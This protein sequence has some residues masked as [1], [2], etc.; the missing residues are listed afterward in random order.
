MEEIEDQM[1][2]EL[3]GEEASSAGS[4]SAK[5]V[6]RMQVDA[7]YERP[8][9]MNGIGDE[10]NNDKKYCTLAALPRSSSSR[11]D[12]ILY[13]SSSGSLWNGLLGSGG[14]MHE[15]SKEIEIDQF[16]N[17]EKNRNNSYAL[18]E[19]SENDIRCLLCESP[20]PRKICSKSRPSSSCGS[21]FSTAAVCF[22]GVGGVCWG[23]RGD[24]ST[25]FVCDCL[26]LLASI[27]S[28]SMM[29]ESFC[30]WASIL[31]HQIMVDE[32]LSR[33]TYGA[34]WGSA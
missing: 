20:L 17:E 13:M 24:I 34:W 16:I 18:V 26:S 9:G 27:G 14:L 30:P 28:S 23:S 3:Q 1:G 6:H 4:Q 19:T 11:R 2:W 31:H 25:T 7:T 32:R 5:V 12:S 29:V 8:C 15:K 10:K 22:L 21:F 33:G